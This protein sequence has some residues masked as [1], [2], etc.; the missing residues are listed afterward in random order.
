M[1]RFCSSRTIVSQT[2]VE[3]PSQQVHRTFI[4]SQTH[5]QTQVTNYHLTNESAT[6]I[7]SSHSNSNFFVSQYTNES[8][9]RT[10][11]SHNLKCSNFIVSQ[12][13]VQLEL[14]RLTNESVSS[15]HKRKCNFI[16]SQTKVQLHRLTNESAT[17]S[18][19]KRKCN[20]SCIVSQSQVLELHRLT[21]ASATRTSSSHK[22]KCIIV[23]QTK[24]LQLHRL[25]NESATSAASSHKR[26]RSSCIVS[27]TSSHNLMSNCIFMSRWS[28]SNTQMAFRRP[29]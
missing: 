3:L 27:Q 16:I 6:R 25:T 9:T 29:Q 24:V 21:N 28:R 1:R 13:Q 10:S 23:S 12:T 19:H 2:L 7:A 20:V 17:S 11:S 8:A 15:S 18:S 26:K 22:R 5:A 14:R 4:V